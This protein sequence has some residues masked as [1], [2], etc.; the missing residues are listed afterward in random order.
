MG[1]STIIQ[2][3]PDGTE[4]IAEPWA[5]PEYPGIRIS[6]RSP[7]REDELLCFAEYSSSK[8]EGKNL[9][10]AAY[11]ADIDEPAYYESY[12]D[13]QLPSKNT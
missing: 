12:S 13:T 5:E 2:A 9:C 11:S 4:L 7:G 3:L 10:I 1:K 8:P 6:L